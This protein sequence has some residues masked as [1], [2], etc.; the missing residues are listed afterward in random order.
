[1]IGLCHRCFTSGVELVL[2]QVV[3]ND[4][5]ISEV[6]LCDKCRK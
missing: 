6:P 2:T 4:I 3:K 1:M 5:G